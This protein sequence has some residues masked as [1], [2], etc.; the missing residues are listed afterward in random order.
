L[1]AVASVKDLLLHEGSMAAQIA[2][3]VG[4]DVPFASDAVASGVDNFM[5]AGAQAVQKPGTDCGLSGMNGGMP[6]GALQHY[7]RRLTN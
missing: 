3:Q 5:P 1:E 7:I 6:G 2:A 4:C